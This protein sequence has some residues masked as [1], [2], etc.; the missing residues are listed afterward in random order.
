MQL[1]V[2]C[3]VLSPSHH[4]LLQVL[5]LLLVRGLA[6]LLLLL[7]ALLGS[8]WERHPSCPK[9]QER[10]QQQAPLPSRC[11]TSAAA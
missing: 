11:C 9:P 10:Q 8:C 6:L 3:L 7:A 4:L 5:V 1:Q 2:R